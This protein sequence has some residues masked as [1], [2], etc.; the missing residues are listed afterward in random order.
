MGV[1]SSDLLYVTYEVL[2]QSLNAFSRSGIYEFALQVEQVP[3]ALDPKHDERAS[4]ARLEADAPG[5]T[6]PDAHGSSQV[7]LGGPEVVSEQPFGREG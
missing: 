7:V 1:L 2:D 6:L 4:R 5:A 3:E